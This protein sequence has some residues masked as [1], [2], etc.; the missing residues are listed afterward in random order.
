MGE[1]KS[2]DVM[3]SSSRFSVRPSLQGSRSMQGTH[4]TLQ[5]Q[6]GPDFEQDAS[7]RWTVESSM[8]VGAGKYG[9]QTF[10][11]PSN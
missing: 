8:H 9:L 3:S 2:E 6:V 1:R 10:G 4:G 11:S 5:L 7:N